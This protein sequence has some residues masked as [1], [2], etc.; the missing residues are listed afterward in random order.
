MSVF[1]PKAC[2]WVECLFRASCIKFAGETHTHLIF[3]LLVLSSRHRSFEFKWLENHAIVFILT[4]VGCRLIVGWSRIA[5][6]I[7]TQIRVHGVRI[8][9]CLWDHFLDKV[10]VACFENAIQLLLVLLI[11][12]GP[13]VLPLSNASETLWLP[14][15][16]RLDCAQEVCWNLCLVNLT[17]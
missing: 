10:L 16:W 11:L 5:H 4:P 15:S 3:W 13:Q 12:N 17:I 8:V 6:N 7:R 1:H 9:P 2:N 14:R